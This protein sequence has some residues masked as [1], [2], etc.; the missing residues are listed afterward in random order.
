MGYLQPQISN[1]ISMNQLIKKKNVK[2]NH[3]HVRY[4]AFI[5]TFNR[6]S[7]HTNNFLFQKFNNTK[8]FPIR[9]RSDTKPRKIKFYLLP[10]HTH[11]SGGS[12]EKKTP[13][14]RTYLSYMRKKNGCIRTPG[15]S[16]AWTSSLG[17]RLARAP[18]KLWPERYRVPIPGAC[19]KRK[20]HIPNFLREKSAFTSFLLSRSQRGNTHT[21]TQIK[22]N[23]NIILLSSSILSCF[24]LFEI[25]SAQFFK[26]GIRFFFSLW[27][28][29]CGS[30]LGRNFQFIV[31]LFRSFSR[32]NIE[33]VCWRKTQVSGIVED[34]FVDFKRLFSGGIFEGTKVEVMILLW[35]SLV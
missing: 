18:R 32:F 26:N 29:F 31:K 8:C 6:I 12:E 19:L 21:H 13:V 2:E 10:P 15:S 17:G 28:S 1:G 11:I 7:S 22:L 3:N 35:V 16:D 30:R 4:F 34:F 5:Q 33:S 14:Y 24:L 9:K 23:T 25:I 20:L 27:C